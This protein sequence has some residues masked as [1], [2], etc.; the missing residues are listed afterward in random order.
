MANPGQPTSGLFHRTVEHDPDGKILGEILEPV[1]SIIYAI[2]FLI[3]HLE[4]FDVRERLVGDWPLVNWLVCGLA[5]LYGA[6]YAALFLLLAWL[7]F[8]RKSLNA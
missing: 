2:Y 8:R 3:P 5:I 1:R 4:L 7:G 6:A